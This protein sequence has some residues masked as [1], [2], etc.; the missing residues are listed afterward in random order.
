[1]TARVPLP[2]DCGTGTGTVDAR[3]PHVR[4]PGRPDAQARMVL[5]TAGTFPERL[6]ARPCR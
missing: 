4:C 1:M 6:V 3:G 2:T 5:E